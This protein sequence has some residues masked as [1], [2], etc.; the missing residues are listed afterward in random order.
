MPRS[1]SANLGQYEAALSSYRKGLALAEP[2]AATA[3]GHTALF[4]ALTTDPNNAVYQRELKVLYNWLGNF[5]AN[6]FYLNLSAREETLQLYFQGFRLSETLMAADPQN[7][8]AQ[9]DF[10]ISH[11]KLADLLTQTQPQ[12]G[13]KFY[14]L[15]LD[16]TGSLLEATP[17][18]Y[19]WLRR[20]LVIQRKLGALLLGL[21]DRPGALRALLPA[22][23]KVQALS[24]ASPANAELSADLHAGHLALAAA[25]TGAEALEP[26]TQARVLAERL[27]AAHPTDLYARWR[28]ADSY[29]LAA[30]AAFPP[31][32]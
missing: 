11:E 17:N 9:F 10:A 27:S 21:G 2:L 23:E 22:W 19:R 12:E 3:P 20:R 28:L 15:A 25:L 26:Y 32:L 7:A 29:A 6:P 31:A 5:L 8:L 30:L 1:R 16:I 14:R 4:E 13:A 18:Q 24:A